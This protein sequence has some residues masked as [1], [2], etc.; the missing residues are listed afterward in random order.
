M[1]SFSIKRDGAL[2]HDGMEQAQ[3]KLHTTF[4]SYVQELNLNISLLAMHYHR[5][6]SKTKHLQR[7]HA[8]YYQSTRTRRGGITTYHANGVT[9]YMK[10]SPRISYPLFSPIHPKTTAVTI[11]VFLRKFRGKKMWV[12]RRRTTAVVLLLV[13]VIR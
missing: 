7:P 2:R 3:V 9:S 5:N 10:G 4:I 11:L 12:E 6:F 13:G 1:D 8:A